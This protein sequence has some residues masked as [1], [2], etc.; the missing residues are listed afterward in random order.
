MGW[1]FSECINLTSLDV[2]GFKTENVISMDGMFQGCSSLNWLDLSSF[3]T[4][5]L[6][7]MLMMLTG[8]ASIT[9]LDMSSFNTNNVNNMFLM[10][11][12]CVKLTKLTLGNEF[13]T[14]E[15][16]NCQGAFEDCSSLS[17][18]SFT[19][20]IPSSINSQFF[21]G[22]GNAENPA[23]LEVPAEYRDHYA[24]KMNGNLFFG[25]YFKLSGA[26]T[27]PLLA[28]D[29]KV[30]NAVDGIVY[31]DYL[32]LYQKWTNTSDDTFTGTAGYS[33][34]VYENNRWTGLRGAGFGYTLKSGASA[35]LLTAKC[36][37]FE[38]GTY[39]IEWWYKVEGSEEEVVAYSTIVEL[40]S[41]DSWKAVVMDRS[42][43][44]TYSDEDD[45]DFSSVYGLKAYTA[46]GFNTATGEALMMRVNDV[47]AG[48]GLL[49]TGEPWYC[50][51]VP[52]NTSS[53][54]Y[55]NMLKG[56]I[57]SSERVEAVSDGYKNYYF[58]N[59][60][61]R[62]NAISEKGTSIDKND[63]YLQI[64]AQAAGSRQTIT[65]KFDDTSGIGE[66]SS[67]EGEPFDVYSLSG[68]LVKRGATTLKG[69]PAGIYV[70]N[71]RK[72][73]VR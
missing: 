38:D 15:D 20:D 1:M 31:S 64:P 41:H 28:V 70:V 30:L 37:D 14:T 18:I 40:R 39:K 73:V 3:K 17:T 24:A 21:F 52:R 72:M 58:A 49:L 23:T 11:S 8:C 35:G 63:A 65:L 2:S 12:S 26:A 48:T 9:N 27:E 29:A 13:V 45:L 67:A 47:P 50:Y 33:F 60:S 69:L 53:T 61:R 66:V 55:V 54:I 5:K 42:G 51:L 36:N 56:V 62:F 6:T 57:G 25:G 44:M 10:L 59:G 34:S 7:N 43:I 46:G 68:L 71:G 32:H 19:G 4:D 16:L 22:V